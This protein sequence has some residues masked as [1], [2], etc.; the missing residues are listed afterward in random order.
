[1]KQVIIMNMLSYV[2]GINNTRDISKLSQISLALRLVK[3]PT[4]I[5]KYH[6]YLCQISLQII[7][8]PIQIL[9]RY[10]R[11]LLNHRNNLQLRNAR[12]LLKLEVLDDLEMFPGQ[13]LIAT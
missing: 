11:T 7:L 3:L 1:M 5:L 6:W 9:R 13:Y 4:T 12:N 8:L 2:I 10:N